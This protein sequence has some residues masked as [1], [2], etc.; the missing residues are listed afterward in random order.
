MKDVV[1]IVIMLVIFV[2]LFLGRPKKCEKGYSSTSDVEENDQETIKNCTPDIG[3]D[4]EADVVK[5]FCNWSLSP[6][7][8]VKELKAG[9]DQY[10]STTSKCPDADMTI[11]CPSPP[12][13]PAPSFTNPNNTDTDPG[14]DPINECKWSDGKPSIQSNCKSSCV[15]QNEDCQNGVQFQKF[16]QNED[17]NKYENLAYGSPPF[18]FNNNTDN[19]NRLNIKCTPAGCPGCCLPSNIDLIQQLK[20]Q[21]TGGSYPEG[22]PRL[23]DY[24]NTCG[25]YSGNNVLTEGGEPDS[26]ACSNE[27]GY[28][29]TGGCFTSSC[30]ADTF[31]IPHNEDGS[32]LYEARD[33]LFH[34]QYMCSSFTEDSNASDNYNPV[35][36]G[37]KDNCIDVEETTPFSAEVGDSLIKEFNTSCVIEKQDPLDQQVEGKCMAVTFPPHDLLSGDK[38]IAGYKSENLGTANTLYFDGAYIAPES[39]NVEDKTKTENPYNIADTSKGGLYGIDKIKHL[40]INPEDT[41]GCYNKTSSEC[42]DSSN[43]VFIN[44]TTTTDGE[45]NN[46]IASDDYGETGMPFFGSTQNISDLRKNTNFAPLIDDFDKRCEGLASVNALTEMS[47]EINKGTCITPTGITVSEQSLPYY[48][49]KVNIDADV[50]NGWAWP[51]KEKNTAE[52]AIAAAQ[53]IFDNSEDLFGTGAFVSEK[54]DWVIQKIPV[55]IESTDSNWQNGANLI[56]N[57]WMVHIPN[58]SNISNI[59][60]DDVIKNLSNLQT[61][62]DNIQVVVHDIDS[63]E[64]DENG[65][66]KPVD[67]YSACGDIN[68][69]KKPVLEDN[70]FGDAGVTNWKALAPTTSEILKE[71]PPKQALK[72]DRHTCM[73]NGRYIKW[74]K[75]KDESNDTYDYIQPGGCVWQPEHTNINNYMLTGNDLTTEVEPD[76]KP[77]TAKDLFY[78]GKNLLDSEDI[79][80]IKF[81]NCNVTQ[82][83]HNGS[84]FNADLVLHNEGSS[85]C[86]DPS[87]CNSGIYGGLCKLD[88]HGNCSIQRDQVSTG[89]LYPRAIGNSSNLF[90]SRLHKYYTSGDARK[91]ST[92]LPSSIFGRRNHFCQQVGSQLCYPRMTPYLLN[93][94]CS[95]TSYGDP[96]TLCQNRCKSDNDKNC[97][98]PNDDIDIGGVQ[99]CKWVNA[100]SDYTTTDEKGNVTLNG[101]AGELIK[102]AEGKYIV[103]PQGVCQ[104]LSYDKDDDTSWLSWVNRE[105]AGSSDNHTPLTDPT[106]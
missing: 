58:I 63:L 94:Y 45:L 30:Q 4:E 103:N 88:D 84:S 22:I 34:T 95:D 28:M 96:K 81:E 76:V 20:A 39:I 64:V 72:G 16:I 68:N 59:S 43:C 9:L 92:D 74:D 36:I 13:F 25:A 44:N 24:I 23:G 102:N 77:P 18:F 85:H 75:L 21:E 40:V 57:H 50:T 27:S 47:Y 71:S 41:S 6:G 42:E 61:N 26:Q 32:S 65:I 69:G 82:N 17:N 55:V 79:G 73:L 70:P 15:S 86:N 60:N 51:Y 91:N 52:G 5:N 46:C 12:S 83:N 37:G 80:K 31:F 105:Y 11:E 106:A 89:Y 101:G 66:L 78:Y 3:Q 53:Y 33:P 97:N 35:Y 10:S 98:I 2:V 14:Y 56:N 54:K 62:A 104:A 48:N 100:E 87:S 49:S 1:L 90:K 93:N 38:N 29:N 99:S 8:V 67:D 19:D 7:N